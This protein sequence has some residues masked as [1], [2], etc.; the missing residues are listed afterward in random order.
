MLSPKRK[1]TGK[2]K[3]SAPNLLKVSLLIPIFQLL[4]KLKETVKGDFGK[5]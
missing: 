1:E 4:T 3:T 2:N 5:C